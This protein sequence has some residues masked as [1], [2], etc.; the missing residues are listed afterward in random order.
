VADECA[1][2]NV[3]PP[4]PSWLHMAVELLRSTDVRRV[5]SF[6]RGGEFASRERPAYG[7][8]GSESRIEP[9]WSFAR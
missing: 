3:A 7:A 1:V 4:L 5:R 6:F 9:R 8:I 2:K